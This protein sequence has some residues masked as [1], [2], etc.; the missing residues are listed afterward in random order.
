MFIVLVTKYGLINLPVFLPLQL[1]KGS[2]YS[3]R[4]CKQSIKYRLAIKGLSHEI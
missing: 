3:N 4:T 1:G 2:V